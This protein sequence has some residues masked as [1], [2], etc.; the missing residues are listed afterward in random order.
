MENIFY[1][2][3]ENF[4]TTEKNLYTKKR[5]I[6]FSF[7]YYKINGIIIIDVILFRH[8]KKIYIKE[9]SK[10]LFMINVISVCI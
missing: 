8:K 3:Q 4:L 2:K 5:K 9:F 1:L 6:Q 7:L 10:R